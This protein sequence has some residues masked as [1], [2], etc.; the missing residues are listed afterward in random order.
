MFLATKDKPLATTITGSLPRPEWFT[1][2]LDGRAFSLAMGDR[3]FREQYNDAVAIS[4]NDQWRAGLDVVSDGDM[5]FDIDVGGRAWHGYVHDRMGGMSPAKRS[6]RTTGTRGREGTPGDIL[7]EVDE[8]RLP[9]TLVGPAT[10]GDLEYTDIWRAA[11]R[12][13][14]KPVKLGCCCGQLTELLLDHEYYSDR[15]E[16]MTAISQALNEEYHE[17]ADA[18]C[19]VIQLEEPCLHFNTEGELGITL[20]QYI[21][22][23]NVETAGLRGKT[24]IWAHTCWGN[25]FAQKIESGYLYKPILS[26]MDQ[27]DADVLTFET[28]ANGGEELEEIGA[29]ISKDKKICIGVVEHRTLQVERPE[30]VAAIIRKA[31]QYIEPERLI[32]SSDCGFGRQGMSRVHAFYKMVAMVWGAN[33]VRNELGLEEVPIPAAEKRFSL[34]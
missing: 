5:R 4:I 23:F 22:A 15:V 33:I 26:H 28:A 2:G 10:R 12:V 1:S 24:E 8:T 32:L 19:P 18:G 13:T 17:L 27:L 25:P 7:H 9:P 31:L 16:A 29:A 14:D 6:A 21:E 20:E 30:E 34:I 11:Q 3:V